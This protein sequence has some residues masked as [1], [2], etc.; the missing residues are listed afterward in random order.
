[1]E[2]RETATEGQR[3]AAAYIQGWFEKLGL[4]PPSANGYQQYFTVFQDSISASSLM[5]DGNNFSYGKDYSI[6][7]SSLAAAIEPLLAD[8]VA[9]SAVLRATLVATRIRALAA[10]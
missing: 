7:L 4:Q 9:P 6:S 3:K 10:D 8:R 5:I 2:G 1:M